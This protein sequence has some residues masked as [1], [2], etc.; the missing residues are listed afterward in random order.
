MKTLLVAL[1]MIA[2]PAPALAGPEAEAKA[3]YARGVTAFELGQFEKAIVSFEKAYELSH[4]V[5]LL[6]NVAQAHRRQYEADKDLAHLKRAKFCYGNFRAMLEADPKKPGAA[7]SIADARR[8]EELVTA[9]IAEVEARLKAEATKPDEP[10]RAPTLAPVAES[11]Q[12]V[13]PPTP[14][15]KKWWLWTAVAAVVVGAGVGL[16]VAFALPNDARPNNTA[17]EVRF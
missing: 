6:W 2:L 5:P 3:E 17:L 13:A 8:E 11:P 15:Y 7:K 16:G 1:V 10:V 4:R 9:Q 12:P 14:I